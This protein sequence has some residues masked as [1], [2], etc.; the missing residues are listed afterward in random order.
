M[1]SGDDLAG[2]EYHGIPGGSQDCQEAV[3]RLLQF[4]DHI[5]RVRILSFS[6]SHCL[7]MT[8]VIG[9][10]IA[11][12]SGFSSGYLGEGPRCFSVV[13]QLLRTHG[14]EVDECE[15]AESLIERLDQSALTIEDIENVDA[16][17]P[18]RPSRWSDYILD[19]HWRN[20]DT[21]TLWQEFPPVVPFAIIDSRLMDLALSFWD[22]PDDKLLKGYRRLEDTVRNRTG[23]T[24]SGSRLFSKTFSGPTSSLHWDGLDEGENSGRTSLF[25]GA[26]SAHRNPRAHREL[27][28]GASNPL[29]EFLLLNHLFHLEKDAKPR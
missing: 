1:N 8:K 4:G 22:D 11:I 21:G 13:L 17:R 16:A 27:Q 12:K 26:Y 7:I 6:N 19:K 2:I 5:V 10:R 24:D 28:S 9:D 23:R 29:S 3:M 14:A 20:A 18:T 15:V 25:I